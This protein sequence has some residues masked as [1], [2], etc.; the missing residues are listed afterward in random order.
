[1]VFALA[2]G[3]ILAGCHRE[4]SALQKAIRA[5]DVAAVRSLLL[6]GASADATAAQRESAWVSA[7]TSLER[8]ESSPSVEVLRLLL[9]EEG[10]HRLVD[11]SFHIDSE[12]ETSAVELAV[13]SWNPG[14]VRTMIECGL[15]VTSQGTTDALVYA[16]A[17]GNDEAA[18]LL[19]EAGASLI[20]RA[21]R[22]SGPMGG[23]SPLEAAR[24]KG[25]VALEEYLLS[26]GAR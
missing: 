18:R 24:R 25:N 12:R 26:R 16:I 4:E 21:S 3:V 7:F 1:M 15:T 5:H 13:R 9:E 8:S 20:D 10:P 17:D 14:A 11:A 23:A 19:V 6:A 2:F 22:G